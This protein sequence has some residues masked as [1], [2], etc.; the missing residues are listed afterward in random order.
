MKPSSSHEMPLLWRGALLYAA[1]RSAPGAALSCVDG[2]GAPAD[3]WLGLKPGGCTNA[4][5]PLC[6]YFASYPPA[7][8]G[9]PALGTLRFA[10]SLAG[11]A[12]SALGATLSAL[13]AARLANATLSV[14]WNDDPP[15]RYLPLPSTAGSFNAHAKGVLAADGSG[16]VWLTHSWPHFPDVPAFA[17]AWG[18][19]EASTIYGQSFLCVSLPLP[20]VERLAGALLRM[21]PRV[22]DAAAAPPAALRSALPTLAALAAGARNASFPL[23]TLTDL[24]SAGGLRFVRPMATSPSSSPSTDA[25]GTAGLVAPTSAS[26]TPGG[27]LPRRLGTP[28][29]LPKPP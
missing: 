6:S 22:Y 1:L 19:G 17:P 27:P 10:S 16:G 7:L 23:P 11:G 5:S 8:S 26:D 24:A 4:S 3:F 13:A 18:I 14:H 28:P 21:E 15:A 29:Q 2:S 25:A 20:Q 9:A 12:A